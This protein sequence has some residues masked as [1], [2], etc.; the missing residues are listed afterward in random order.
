MA[1]NSTY[2]DLGFS[3]PPKEWAISPL[4]ELLAPKGLAIGVMY[5]GAHDPNGVPIVRVKNMQNGGIVTDDVLRVAKEVE[6]KHAGARLQGGE[7]LLS[8]VGSVGRV[9]LVPAEMSGWNTARA[10]AVI[11]VAGGV[12]NS[13]VKIWLSSAPAQHYM[14]SRLN[15]TVQA[16]LNLRDVRNI[17]IVVPPEGDRRAIIEVLGA[18]EDKIASNERVMAT[19]R[20]LGL[21]L[22]AEAIQAGDAIGI[23][24]ESVAS[25]LTRGI[26]PKY[27][28]AFDGLIVLNQK[29]IRGGRVN[30]DPSRLTLREKVGAAKF[31]QR[32]DVLVN[33]TGVGTLGRVARWT[34][35]VEATADSHVTIV[36]FDEKLVDPVC[37]GFA[38]LRSQPKIEAMGEGS[39]GQTELR[40]TQVGGL[41]IMLPS[42]PRQKELRVR[43]DALEER[44]DQAIAESLSLNALRDTVLPQLMS[45]ELRVRDAERIVEDAV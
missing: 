19:S 41:Q 30:L 42:P 23:A 15:T 2:Q 26:A 29:C 31:L 10:V 44:A 32:N 33:S 1:E 17:P 22:F 6:E 43:L 3:R 5:P 8:L 20:E 14:R 27:T 9:A 4:E 12:S 18:L 11:R 16:T 38:M 37:A 45:G 36:R 25:A 24:V 28:D 21:A 13:W 34:S 7:I 35:D 40:R 39:T